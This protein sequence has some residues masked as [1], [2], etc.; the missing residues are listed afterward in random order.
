MDTVDSALLLSLQRGGT[1]IQ[2]TI[3][4]KQFRI[5]YQYEEG[6]PFLTGYLKFVSFYTGYGNYLAF[7]N[8]GINYYYVYFYVP[9]GAA[10]E[11]RYSIKSA[12]LSPF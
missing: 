10:T 7:F 5:R 6:S 11:F 3:L 8:F 4:Y 12:Q 1:N 2:D 9:T